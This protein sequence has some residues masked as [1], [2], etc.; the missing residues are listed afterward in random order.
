MSDSPT[1]KDQLDGDDGESRH[2]VPPPA[3]QGG[4]DGPVSSEFSDEDQ[5]MTEESSPEGGD[6]DLIAMDDESPIEIE[7]VTGQGGTTD[8]VIDPG[9]E[10]M[11]EG[12]VPS[13]DFLAGDGSGNEEP[14]GDVTEMAEDEETHPGEEEP[15]LGDA[16]VDPNA[17]AE[18]EAPPV[19]EPTETDEEVVSEEVDTPDRTDD[20]VDPDGPDDVASD[21]PIVIEGLEER[22]DAERSEDDQRP[23]VPDEDGWETDQDPTERPADMDEPDGSLA[24]DEES[25]RQVE[26]DIEEEP[27]LPSEDDFEGPVGGSLTTRIMALEGSRT[28]EEEVQQGFGR[29]LGRRRMAPPPPPREEDESSGEVFASAD[30]VDHP[31]SDPEPYDTEGLAAAIDELR[32]PPLHEESHDSDEGGTVADAIVASQRQLRDSSKMASNLP[33][34]IRR[35]ALIVGVILVVGGLGFG[36][37]I[38]SR[39]FLSRPENAAPG[40]SV[41]DTVPSAPTTLPPV[42]TTL[43][44]STT[45]TV[46]TQPVAFQLSGPEF[47]QRWNE[48]AGGVIPALRMPALL[49]GDFEIQ[50]TQYITA[51][52]TVDETGKLGSFGIIL[53]PTGPQ[54]AD[55]QGIQTM[56]LFIATVDPNL[57]GPQRK[58]LLASMGFDVDAP[59][60]VGLD[61]VASRNGVSYAL[62][63]DQEAV[64][65]TFSAKPG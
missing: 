22:I 19:V 59:Q 47:V 55:A 50:L 65:L 39:I 54:E 16:V 26:D 10:S 45:T 32:A 37:V 5:A 24:A 64:R 60:L 42:T 31:V 63:Y 9:P 34:Q 7:A 58:E 14:A 29:R 13:R 6:G 1:H 23:M 61:S 49:P 15:G 33:K 20:L 21:H 41:A 57:T 51:A 11:L 25:D 46:L 30:E 18:E 27:F 3:D 35:V 38:A 53:D 4:E 44:E 17:T 28:A 43:I 36:A 40:T 48:T 52:G 2:A 12:F 8:F 62:V 56:G